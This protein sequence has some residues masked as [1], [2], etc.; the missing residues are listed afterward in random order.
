M[1]QLG[2]MSYIYMGWS[3]EAMAEEARNQGMKYVQI[4]PKQAM[5][6]MD[7]QPFSPARVEKIRS[8]F[9]NKGITVIGL[10]GY[11]NLMNPNLPKGKSSWSN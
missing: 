1:N 10:S 6:V 11:T 7:D 8:I 2:F 3:A 9:E 5:Q 4:D